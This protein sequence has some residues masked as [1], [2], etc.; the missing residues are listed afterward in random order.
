M[1][2]NMCLDRFCANF[3]FCPSLHPDKEACCSSTHPPRLPHLFASPSS[4]ALNFSR[5][6]YSLLCSVPFLIDIHWMKGDET[7]DMQR[8]SHPDL[9]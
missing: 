1:I 4:P 2:L 7:E 9:V 8:N 6:C 3:L 5:L